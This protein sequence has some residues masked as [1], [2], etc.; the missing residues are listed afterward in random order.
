[1]LTSVRDMVRRR[2]AVE[3]VFQI[4]ET[5]PG[6]GLDSRAKVRSYFRIQQIISKYRKE[7]GRLC[8]AEILSPF[9]PWLFDGIDTLSP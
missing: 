3:F 1:M 5:F 6:I 2:E 8:E 9:R 4:S 7:G